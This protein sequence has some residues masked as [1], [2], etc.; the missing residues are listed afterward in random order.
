MNSNYKLL[1][2]SPSISRVTG[3]IPNTAYYLTKT[4]SDDY[5]TTCFLYLD[6]NEPIGNVKYNVF[7][8]NKLLRTIKSA[9]S[10]RQIANNKTKN[11]TKNITL[12]MN[13]RYALVPYLC[14]NI[15]KSPY[16]ILCHGNDVLPYGTSFFK[17][18]EEKLRYRILNNARYL[19]ANSQYTMVLTQKISH[20]RNIKI[21]H[22]CSGELVSESVA[23]NSK[24]PKFILSIGRL[25]ERKGFQYVIEAMA[26]IKD[27]FPDLVY[28]IAGDGPYRNEL[29]NKIKEFNLENKCIL[30]GRISEEKKQELF[31]N[32][33]LLVMPSFHDE[34]HMSV[35][36][37]GIVY[38]EANAH[39]KPVIGTRSG[40]IPDAIIEGKTGLLVDVKN[41]E[42]LTDAMNEILSGKVH[43]DKNFCRDWASKHYYPEIMNQYKELIDSII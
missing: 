5:L 11:I 42:Q 15:V 39:G 13:W 8:D 4:L 37:F 26:R 6:E 14:R 31:S 29:E 17:R 2:F 40:G 10:Y 21:I 7:A 20:S 22:P 34:A 24:Y 19:C 9:F 3:G 30:L 41:V 1:I 33:E 16:I 18:F 38:I 36:G 27:Q 35:E 43:F 32:C 25:E 28:Y 12:C 23:D